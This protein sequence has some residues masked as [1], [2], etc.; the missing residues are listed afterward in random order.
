MKSNQGL[1]EIGRQGEA[2]LQSQVE[3]KRVAVVRTMRAGW[4]LCGVMVLV[5]AGCAKVEIRQTS[6][7]EL[8]KTI[9]RA[10][11]AIDVEGLLVCTHPADR[12]VMRPVYQRVAKET[13][14]ADV[15]AEIIRQKIGEKE[16][17]MLHKKGGHITLR[18][19]WSMLNSGQIPDWRRYSFRDNG[20]GE[21]RLYINEKR[22][23]IT[24]AQVFGKW[25]LAPLSPRVR[26]IFTNRDYGEYLE[27]ESRDMIEE[28][29]QVGKQIQEGEMNRD[30]YI[31]WIQPPP[32]VDRGQ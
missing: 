7:L 14:E 27:E 4:L 28:F 11:E 17:L 13:C 16:S 32:V 15:L 26:R 1:E 21:V 12:T 10:E 2:A 18:G 9:Y 24:M 23:S 19:T 29:R 22:T 30:E 31:R 8:M 3:P 25:Y 6:P 5:A 20:T